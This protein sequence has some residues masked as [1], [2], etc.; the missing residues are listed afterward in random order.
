MGLPGRIQTDNR[1]LMQV[2][3]ETAKALQP[4]QAIPMLGGTV[5][6]SISL[7]AASTNPVPH[8]LN[9]VPSYWILVDQNTNSI[10]WRSHASDSQFLYLQCSANCVVSLWVN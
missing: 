9:R 4:V 1:Q 5:L 8:G 3:D 7:V 2:Q 10:V 6:K